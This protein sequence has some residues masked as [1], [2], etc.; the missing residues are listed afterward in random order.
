VQGKSDLDQLRRQAKDLLRAARTGDAAALKRILAV[1]TRLTLGSAQLAIA[2]EKGFPSWP[3]MK[4][5]FERIQAEDPD[6]ESDEV[7]DADWADDTDLPGFRGWTD[8]G[9]PIQEI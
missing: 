2:R 6:L 9:T 5:E 1:E 3:K 4:A 8:Q 7:D